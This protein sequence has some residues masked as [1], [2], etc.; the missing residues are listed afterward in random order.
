MQQDLQ[1]LKLLSIFFY[2]WGGLACLGA[3]IGAISLFVAGAAMSSLPSSSEDAQSQAVMGPVFIVMGIVLL[4]AGLIYGILAIMAGGKF[5]KHLGGYAFCL[6]ISII[7]CISSFPIGTAL[8][9]FA[10]VVLMRASVKELFKGQALPGTAP[11]TAI[12]PVS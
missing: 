2:V 1:Q 7:T 9:I 6:V 8:G 12:P 4:I 5:K 11:A 10:I 3:V